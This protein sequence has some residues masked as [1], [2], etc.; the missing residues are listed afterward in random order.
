MSK[1]NDKDSVQ[2]LKTLIKKCRNHKLKRSTDS[3][4]K[5]EIFKFLEGSIT[6]VIQKNNEN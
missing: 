6:K 5:E 4:A 3:D 1:I 2:I